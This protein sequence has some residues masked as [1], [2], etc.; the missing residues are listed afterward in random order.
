MHLSF[1]GIGDGR[2]QA[3]VSALTAG[4]VTIEI[5]AVQENAT[6]FNATKTI[7]IR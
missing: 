1:K 4:R 5:M 2:Y 3:D 6:S 7:Q